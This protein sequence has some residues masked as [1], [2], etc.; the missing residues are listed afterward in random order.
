MLV[1]LVNFNCRPVFLVT[2]FCSLF[3]H[4][5]HIFL[6]TLL[7]ILC[8][9][10]AFFFLSLLIEAM[11]LTKKL[12]KY[13]IKF[14]LAFLPYLKIVFKQFYCSIFRV[15]LHFVL[16]CCQQSF[17][18]TTHQRLDQTGY[19]RRCHLPNFQTRDSTLRSLTLKT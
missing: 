17:T 8:S 12:N 3:C 6:I 19:H 16:C 15:R 9:Y 14:K 5:I 2:L 7:F 10:V 11:L 18:L 4:R 1:Y 13:T